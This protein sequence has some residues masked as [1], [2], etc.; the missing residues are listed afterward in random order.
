MKSALVATFQDFRR[1]LGVCPCCGEVFR[2]TDLMIAYRAKPAVTW[3]DSL[4]ADEGRQQRVE[5]RFAEDEQRIRELAKERGRR[6]LPRLLREAEPL[7]DPVDYI[8]FDGMNASPAVTRIVLFDGPAL[9]HA[10]ERV[11]RSIQ[12]AL[13]A[14]NCEWKT[15]RMGKDGRI[16]PERGR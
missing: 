4:E 3:L 10:R 14:G 5:D 2:L 11:Q 15:V 7:F 13:E 9:G 1:I 12:R 6:A 16:Q 8:V